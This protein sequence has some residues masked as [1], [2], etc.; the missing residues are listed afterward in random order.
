[1]HLVAV[2]LAAVYTTPEGMSS[3]QITLVA[4]TIY[5]LAQMSILALVEVFTHCI[6]NLHW[7]FCIISFSGSFL[8]AILCPGHSH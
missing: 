3:V 4:F 8:A 6:D 5:H 1:M 7:R 2:Y